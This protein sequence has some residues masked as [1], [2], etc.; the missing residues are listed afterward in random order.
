M[1]VE[2][3]AIAPRNMTALEKVENYGRCDGTAYKRHPFRIL[4]C[5]YYY[6]RHAT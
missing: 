4:C 3:E 6:H 2:A 1:E 5:C